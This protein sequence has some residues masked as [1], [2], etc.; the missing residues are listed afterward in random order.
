MALIIE[1]SSAQSLE[2][3]LIAASMVELFAVLCLV[4]VLKVFD[5]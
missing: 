5:A 2:R 1:A 3:T 4:G